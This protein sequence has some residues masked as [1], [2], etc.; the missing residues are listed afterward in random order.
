MAHQLVQVDAA[1]S[2]RS[3]VGA[4][5]AKCRKQKADPVLKFWRWMISHAVA[6]AKR[7]RA[8]IPTPAAILARWWLEEH[9]PL[10]NE[11]AE[12]ERSFDCCCSWL[13]DEPAVERKRLLAEIDAALET[14]WRDHVRMS[15]YQ[16]RAS[17][18]SC[19]GVRTAIGRQHVL[20]LVDGSEYE[21]VAGIEHGDPPP[22]VRKTM[23]I[24]A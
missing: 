10:Q 11:T 21:H 14:A 5:P 20:P 9:K 6:D 19:A 2:N 22:R 24:A 23:Q 16:L 3:L 15:V 12:W 4:A 7:T 17:V 18:L 8:G 13:G 1:R